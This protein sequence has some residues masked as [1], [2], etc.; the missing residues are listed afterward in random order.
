MKCKLKQQQKIIDNNYL[1]KLGKKSFK[2]N[3]IPNWLFPK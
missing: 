2:A 1:E 3:F